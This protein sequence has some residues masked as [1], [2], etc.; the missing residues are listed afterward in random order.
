M[1]LIKKGR[2]LRGFFDD[3][4]DRRRVTK[5]IPKKRSPKTFALFKDQDS[6]NSYQFLP[7][8]IGAVLILINLK[9]TVIRA[10]QVAINKLEIKTW[11][12]LVNHLGNE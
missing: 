8:E 9:I 12:V 4:N 3:R 5:I 6:P 11:T 7:R 1:G 2:S 10:A